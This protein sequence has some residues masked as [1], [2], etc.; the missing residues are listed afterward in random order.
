MAVESFTAKDVLRLVPGLKYP[1]LNYWLTSNLLDSS[2]RAA[3]GKGSVRRFAFG[4][5]LALRVIT[6][7][8]GS[9]L[10]LQALRKVVRHLKRESR[11][12]H[13]LTSRTLVIVPGERPDVASVVITDDAQA[14]LESLLR[15][16]GQRLMRAVVLPL[17]PLEAE[18]RVRVLD[19]NREREE[20]EAAKRERQRAQQREA[21]RRFRARH[22][23][24]RGAVT[25]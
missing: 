24:Q 1:T 4:D 5:L 8:R 23:K 15:A 20:R 9:G 17:A 19:F 25:G 2:V 14:E 6:E 7:L 10:S 13:P 16:P 22:Q 11:T 3:H 12:A 18:V 21:S